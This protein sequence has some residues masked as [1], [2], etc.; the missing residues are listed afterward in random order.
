MPLPLQV[1]EDV[2]MITERINSITKRMDRELE[3]TLEES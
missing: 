2:A 1:G 3:A